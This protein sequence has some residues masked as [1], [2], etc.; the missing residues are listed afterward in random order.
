VL[1]PA[2]DGMEENTTCT[3]DPSTSRPSALEV[4][5][6]GLGT[7]FCYLVPANLHYQEVVV[8]RRLHQTR[9]FLSNFPNPGP[10]EAADFPV[11]WVRSADR[12]LCCPQKG[13]TYDN[14]PPFFL[15]WGS[16]NTFPPGA[17]SARKSFDYA[18]VLTGGI[19]FSTFLLM[20][21][22]GNLFYWPVF[23]PSSDSLSLCLQTC[24]LSS[25]A[26]PLER[27]LDPELPSCFLGAYTTGLYTTF[28]SNDNILL[29]SARKIVTHFSGIIDTPDIVNTSG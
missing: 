18:C 28:A 12:A 17:L 25:C 29:S 7:S 9:E 24:L 13:I 16:C 1:F 5:F 11:G 4:P 3:P 8:I 20:H 14:D 27:C 2:T 15:S 6:D 26:R 23:C 22:V 21:W 19:S 10:R